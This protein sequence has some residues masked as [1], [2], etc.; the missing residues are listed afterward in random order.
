M[1]DL[2][3]ELIEYVNNLPEHKLKA[4]LTIIKLIHDCQC[5]ELIYRKAT[6]LYNE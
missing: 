2:R 6:E 1:S 3:K 4:L 5:D